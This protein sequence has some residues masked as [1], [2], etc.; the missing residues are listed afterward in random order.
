MS[1]VKQTMK[2]FAAGKLHSGSKKGPLVTNP[3]QAIAIALNSAGASPGRMMVGN[4][5]M[6]DAMAPSMTPGGN[7]LSTRLSARSKLK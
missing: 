5:M 4:S 3:K 2:E 1:G 7:T 6:P